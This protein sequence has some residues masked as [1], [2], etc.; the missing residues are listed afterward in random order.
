MR[1]MIS[2]LAAL[3]FAALSCSAL[4]QP[5]PNKPVR[6]IVAF[7][8]GGGVDIVARQLAQPQIDWLRKSAPAR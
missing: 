5:F 6:I 7:P 1:K 4:A 8:P 2:L 3:G